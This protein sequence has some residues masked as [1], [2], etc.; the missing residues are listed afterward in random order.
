MLNINKYSP[1]NQHNNI[2]KNYRYND[3]PF[4]DSF[5]LN[6][7]HKENSFDKNFEN[8]NEN[9]ENGDLNAIKDLENLG[10][11]YTKE[12]RPNGY[13]I[14]YEYENTNYTISYSE[15][16]K[17]IEMG[18]KKT[19]NDKL[20]KEGYDIILNFIEKAN[21]ENAE[22]FMNLAVPQAPNSKDYQ[23]ESEYNAA[24]EQY[25]KD[26]ESYNNAVKQHNKE[27]SVLEY[28][29]TIISEKQRLKEFDTNIKNTILN[30][31]QNGHKNREKTIYQLK[32]YANDFKSKVNEKLYFKSQLYDC[33]TDL[34]NLE[35]PNFPVKENYTSENEYEK[36]YQNYEIKT[37]Q[38]NMDQTAIELKMQM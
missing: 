38:Y 16:N 1:V 12:E 36:A 17:Q 25:H 21:Q 19:T 32:E 30:I 23:N 20:D 24:L 18:N 3:K 6:L 8:I 26:Y 5:M 34:N 15:V 33:K 35:I 7:T 29:S 31:Q 11:S 37:S 22:E 4:K 10:I 9:L 14:S 13:K 2:K 27:T 28:L